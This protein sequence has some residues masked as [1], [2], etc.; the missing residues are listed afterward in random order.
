MSFIDRMRTFFKQARRQSP[1]KLM[2]ADISL[3]L[4][5]LADTLRERVEA[6]ATGQHGLAEASIEYIIRDRTGGELQ[7][8]WQ[9]SDYVTTADIIDTDGYKALAQSSKH[10]GIHLKLTEEQIEEVDDEERVRFCII[11]SGWGK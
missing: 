11:L 2:L 10:D 5:G 7:S 6:A 4:Q 9:D 3:Q 1:T 8:A